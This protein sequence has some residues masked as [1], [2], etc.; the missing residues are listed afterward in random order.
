MSATPRNAALVRPIEALERLFFR[1]AERN[2]VHFLLV[3]EFDAVLDA[4]LLRSALDS[5][6]QRHPLL[7]VHVEDHP[8]SRLGF[9]RAQAVARIPLTV[10][11]EVLTGGRE[12]QRN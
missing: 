5:V 4:Q 11:R 9:Y 3:A 10:H 1:Y 6:Q 7:S 2:P 12:P 8:S